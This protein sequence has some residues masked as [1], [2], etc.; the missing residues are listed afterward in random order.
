MNLIFEWEENKA[1]TNAQKHRVGFDE[2]RTLSND[3]RLLTYPDEYHSEAEDRY[4]SVGQSARN[5]VLLV[6]HTEQEEA[7]DRLIV[8]IISCR[9][10][11]ASERQAYEESYE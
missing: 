8:R 5:R 6:V 7:E 4:I 1:R 3:P 11:A 10:A 2:A 9:K